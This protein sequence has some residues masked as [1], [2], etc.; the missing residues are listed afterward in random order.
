MS[1]VTLQ[2]LETKLGIKYN[3]FLWLMKNNTGKENWIVTI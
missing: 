2:G 1:G 3:L